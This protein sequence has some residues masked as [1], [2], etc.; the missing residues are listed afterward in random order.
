[1]VHEEATLPGVGCRGAI[2]LR[3]DAGM[4]VCLRRG[5]FGGFAVVPAVAQTPGATVQLLRWDLPEV[6][7]PPE[8]ISVWVECGIAREVTLKKRGPQRVQYKCRCAQGA[9]DVWPDVIPIEVA[10]VPSPAVQ[11]P[12]VEA[13]VQQTR[14]TH[15]PAVV[16]FGWDWGHCVDCVAA[17]SSFFTGGKFNVSCQVCTLPLFLTGVGC[18]KRGCDP[19][20]VGNSV[21]SLDLMERLTV[22]SV[23]R[24]L[25]SQSG[26]S[27]HAAVRYRVTG[28][29][30]PWM[31]EVNLP[32]LVG[33]EM[34]A[35]L[36]TKLRGKILAL[37]AIGR[38]AGAS[39]AER[40]P[41]NLYRVLV[42][43]GDGRLRWNLT[44]GVTWLRTLGGGPVPEEAAQQ[45]E[46]W[47]Q[48]LR[49][50]PAE[51]ALTPRSPT[52]PRQPAV[53]LRPRKVQEVAKKEMTP[54]A[55]K[56][57]ECADLSAVLGPL[58]D[59]R[60][61]RMLG[62][63]KDFLQEH[64]RP[65][66]DNDKVRTELQRVRKLNTELLKENKVQKRDLDKY[67]HREQALCMLLNG[68]L[69][70]VVRISSYPTLDLLL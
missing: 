47:Q 65:A 33:V 54:N 48:R 17:A 57:P 23:G 8:A 53:S 64:A 18:P 11:G 5:T 28:G 60:M 68:A 26:T 4:V 43:G 66:A 9:V 15:T 24:C 37:G 7:V 50:D 1:M 52:P 21:A 63:L 27:W 69:T 67:F 29:R 6:S 3:V 38:N 30:S 35:E 59:E 20:G 10:E 62:Q 42:E 41:K 34:T 58:L 31:L 2:H 14:T 13:V 25:G 56:A 40:S 61:N 12:P 22:Q 49:G 46:E 32:C 39:G 45:L 36:L 19:V 51:G 16:G 70:S 44:T 55:P